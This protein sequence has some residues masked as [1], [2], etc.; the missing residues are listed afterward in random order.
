[1][2]VLKVGSVTVPIENIDYIR[3]GENYRGDVI[4]LKTGVR[5][6]CTREEFRFIERELEAA[7]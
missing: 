7:Q 6:E 4:V 3:E 2:K 1:M 5:I